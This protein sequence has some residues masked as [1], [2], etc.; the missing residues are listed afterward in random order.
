MVPVDATEHISDVI[1]A[2]DPST[3]VVRGVLT[4][5]RAVW[6]LGEEFSNEGDIERSFKVDVGTHSGALGVLM[7]EKRFLWMLLSMFVMVLKP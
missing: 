1:E 3:V 6:G 7:G 5:V 4:R 2:F